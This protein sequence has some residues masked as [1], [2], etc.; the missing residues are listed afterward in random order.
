MHSTLLKRLTPSIP[1]ALNLWCKDVKEQKLVVE[2]AMYTVVRVAYLTKAVYSKDLPSKQYKDGREAIKERK[3][4]LRRQLNKALT[5]LE[6]VLNKEYHD[7][8]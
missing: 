1:T 5:D 3:Q 4:I 7:A 6:N 8:L 2:R